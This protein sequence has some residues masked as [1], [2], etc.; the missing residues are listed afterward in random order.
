MSVEEAIAAAAA[1]LEG[2]SDG[3]ESASAE[4]GG[5]ASGG[6]GADAGVA[7]VGGEGVASPDGGDGGVAAESPL[8]PDDIDNELAA[9][10]IKA[11]VEG[12]RENRLPYSRVRKIVEN[13][14]KKLTDAHTTELTTRDGKLTAAEARLKLVEQ[15]EQLASTDPDRYLAMLAK[16]NPAYARFLASPAAEA[17]PAAK[18][19]EARPA[20]DFTYEDGSK[21]YTEAGLEKLLQWNADQA[22]TA[23][24]SRVEETYSKRFGPIE[25]QWKAQQVAAEQMPRI[26]AQIE[27][28]VKTWGKTFE[29][30]YKLNDKSEVLQYMKANP[31]VPFDACVAAV[32]LPKAQLDRN[33]MRADLLTEINARPAAAAKGVLPVAKVGAPATLDGP[34]RLEDV[35]AEAAAA[36][37]LH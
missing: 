16:S 15:A 7:A 30:D 37:G 18:A 21:G 2:G 11:P 14:R 13:A 25:E 3:A 10:G 6:E 28:A 27:R 29:D 4:V 31:D 35:I 5:G 1:T 32:M 26:N 17:K 24:V 33:K 36:A 12:Q 34:R 9:L 8:L 20:P 19:V 22:V 23:A